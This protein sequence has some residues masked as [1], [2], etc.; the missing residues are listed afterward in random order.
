M[1]SGVLYSYWPPAA[2]TKTRMK[3]EQEYFD[4]RRLRE[5]PVSGENTCSR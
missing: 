5:K 4:G 3:S 1:I 2:E